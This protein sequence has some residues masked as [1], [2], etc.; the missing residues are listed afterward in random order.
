MTE[1]VDTSATCLALFAGFP[2]RAPLDQGGRTL[3]LAQGSYAGFFQSRDKASRI[4]NEQPWSYLFKTKKAYFASARRHSSN[5]L[6]QALLVVSAQTGLGTTG[7]RLPAS[8]LAILLIAD[9]VEG[10]WGANMMSV[11]RHEESTTR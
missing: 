6:P 4:C 3:Y 2:T 8:P 5:L 10:R 1:T 9:S 11:R 7:A